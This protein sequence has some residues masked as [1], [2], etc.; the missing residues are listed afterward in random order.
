MPIYEFKCLDCSEEFELL[1]VV[2]F[3]S[4]LPPLGIVNAR[5]AAKE[6]VRAADIEYQ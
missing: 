2:E 6:A 3:F 1:V 4:L 5:D